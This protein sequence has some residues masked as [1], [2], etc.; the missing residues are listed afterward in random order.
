MDDPLNDRFQSLAA[1]AKQFWKWGA[2]KKIATAMDTSTGSVS[3]WIKSGFTGNK[4]QLDALS[5]ALS[6]QKYPE[7]EETILMGD[8]DRKGPLRAAADLVQ[9]FTAPIIAFAQGGDEAYPEDLEHAAPRISVPCKDPNC[10]VLE[11]EGDSMAPTYLEGDLLVVAPNLEWIN[12]DLVIVK[13][14]EGKV[15]F[16][17]IKEKP[18]SKILQFESFN[19]NHMPIHLRRDEIFKISVVDCVIRPL[20]RR[21]RAM[22]VDPLSKMR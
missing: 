18:G 13:T 9:T 15:A 10:Y 16:K 19:S 21:L 4:T 14:H 7:K 5:Q 3:A 20:K 8:R 12:N 6:S 2:Q 11:L 1:E 17:K 22:T